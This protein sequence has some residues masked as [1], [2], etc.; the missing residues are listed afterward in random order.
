MDPNQ[1]YQG[2]SIKVTPEALAAR[3][4]MSDDLQEKLT[5]ITDQLAFDPHTFENSTR[6]VSKNT[7]IYEHPDPAFQITYQLKE[8]IAPKEL[9]FVHFAVLKI[10]VKRLLFISYS[11]A[12]KKWLDQLRKFLVHF[13]DQD[14]SIWDDRQINAG[15]QWKDEIQKALR[16][17]KAAVLLISQDFLNS[18]FIKTEE[19]PALLEKAK[20]DGL[21]IFWVPVRPSTVLVD[22]SPILNFQAAI[23]RPEVALSALSKAKWE[24]QLISVREK[25]GTALGLG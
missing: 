5:S 9:T 8:D 12:D 23:E 15:A 4:E 13:E 14:I 22:Q 19:L 25:I 21:L 16:D 18:K 11:H 2:Y 20:S 1:E 6:S 10:V 17:A 7:Y 24:L 3:R